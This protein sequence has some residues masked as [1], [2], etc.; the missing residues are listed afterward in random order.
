MTKLCESCGCRFM[1]V[2]RRG[3]ILDYE[4]IAFCEP[5][6]R[7]GVENTFFGAF[8]LLRLA[9]N[10]LVGELKI[11]FGRLWWV[12]GKRAVIRAKKF[13]RFLFYLDDSN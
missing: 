3:P 11:H 10:D 4:Y 12:Y 8:T 7:A 5:C 13:L 9:W 1:V 2:Y 6:R